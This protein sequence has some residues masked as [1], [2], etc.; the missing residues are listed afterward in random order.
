MHKVYILFMATILGTF[1]LVIPVQF[2]HGQ[3]F[4]AP[5]GN[6]TIIADG[7]KGALDVK[8]AGP[9]FHPPKLMNGMLHS[10]K[11]IVGTLK[12]GNDPMQK[13]IGFYNDNLS[14]IIFIRVANSTNLAQ[15]E[16]FSGY[17]I[18]GSL[19]NLT[20]LDESCRKAGGFENTH[21]L[22]G[23]FEALSGVQALASN[24]LRGW[25]AEN[26]YCELP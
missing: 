5:I 18:S 17:V 15:D 19:S 10:G 11:D 25:Y 22:T 8:V 9:G 13:I 21:T 12:L 6:W 26:S 24:N 4:V 16:I 23:T 20:N 7:I 14:R 3:G 1:V 2:V